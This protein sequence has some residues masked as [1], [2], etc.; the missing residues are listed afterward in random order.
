MSRL[1]SK[2]RLVGHKRAK[3]NSRPNTSLIQIEGV[4]NKEEAQFYL[5]KVGPGGAWCIV[6]AQLSLACCVRVQGQDRTRGIQRPR[7]LGVSRTFNNS[8]T[9][10]YEGL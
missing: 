3:R 10:I 9:H 2:G 6:L 4:A 1:Y 5:G 8:G 7:Y